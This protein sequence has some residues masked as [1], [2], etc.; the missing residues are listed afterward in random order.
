MKPM[1]LKK[2]RTLFQVTLH[3]M[4][5][6][7]MLL[8]NIAAASGFITSDL[9][10]IRLQEKRMLLRQADFSEAPVLSQE[11]LVQAP[12]S[13][14]MIG[15]DAPGFLRFAAEIDL[16]GDPAT[17][18]VQSSPAPV[19]NLAGKTYATAAFAVTVFS[20]SD[21][22]LSESIPVTFKVWHNDSLYTQEVVTADAWGAAALE[23]PFTN[24]SGTYTYQ[25]SSPGFGET[26]IRTFIFNP[27]DAAYTLSA[28][29]ARLSAEKLADG[30]MR[31]TLFSP[32]VLDP[33]DLVELQ[34]Y[35]SPETVP[36]VPEQLQAVAEQIVA[37]HTLLPLPY[38]A[39]QIVDEHTAVL[40]LT[41]PRGSYR[42]LGS[43]NYDGP[44]E[45]S[46]T[47]MMDYVTDEDPAPPPDARVQWVSP[48]EHETGQ[49][50]V[51]YEMPAGEAAL[52]LIDSV[53]GDELR[54]ALNQPV[55]THTALPGTITARVRTSPYTW[56]QESFLVEEYLAPGV[57]NDP[58]LVLNGIVYDP[59]TRKFTLN[60]QAGSEAAEIEEAWAV[61][62][63][64]GVVLDSRTWVENTHPGESRTEQIIA[65]ARLGKPQGLLLTLTNPGTREVLYRLRLSATPDDVV[66]LISEAYIQYAPTRA[67]DFLPPPPD[68]KP[69]WGGPDRAD[70]T[71]RDV[72]EIGRR[73]IQKVK[74]FELSIK[75]EVLALALEFEF[76][77]SVMILTVEMVNKNYIYPPGKTGEWTFKPMGA[78]VTEIAEAIFYNTWTQK[79]IA[80]ATGSGS[81]KIGAKGTVKFETCNSEEANNIVNTRLISLADKMNT[82]IANSEFM[83]ETEFGD[84]G[85]KTVG[86]YFNILFF[87]LDWGVTGKNFEAD[88]GDLSFVLNAGFK[89]EISINVGIALPEFISLESVKA[90]YVIIG[91]VALAGDLL[92]LFAGLQN[93]AKSGGCKLPPWPDDQPADDRQDAYQQASGAALGRTTQDSI[94]NLHMLVGLA[95]DLALERAERVLTLQLR[96]YELIQF[97]NNQSIY[98]EY[99]ALHAQVYDHAYAQYQA[100]LSGTVTLSPTQTITEAVTEIYA[101]ANELVNAHPYNI[102]SNQV[103]WKLRVA[104][105][106]YDAL[107]GQ[108][109]QTQE[110]MD[111]LLNTASIGVLASGIPWGIEKA[112]NNI[113]IPYQFVSLWGAEMYRSKPVYTGSP[114]EAPRTLVVPTAGLD[115]VS[116]SI[117]A[118]QW[119]DAYVAGGGTMLVFTQPSGAEWEAL[120]GGE[121]RGIGY[122]EDQ[123]CEQES[124]RAGAP[125]KWLVWMGEPTPDIQV[126]GVFTTWPPEAIPLLLRRS[127]FFEGFP[128]MLEYPYGEGTVLATTAYGDWAVESGIAWGDDWQMTRGLL[129]R[130]FLLNSGRDVEDLATYSPDTQIFPSLSF[131]N[132]ASFTATQVQTSLPIIPA[133]DPRI[134]RSGK[135]IISAPIVLDL[136][137][138]GFQEFA[139]GITTPKTLRGVHNWTQS[140]IFR[141]VNL[142]TTEGGWYKAWGP[143][144]HIPG[145]DPVPDFVL[146]LQTPFATVRPFTTIPV[147]A[148]VQNFTSLS[149][150]VVVNGLA[151][152]P[153]E[154][155]TLTVP[156]NGSASTTYHVLVET[157]LRMQA[158]AYAPN[159]TLLAEAFLSVQLSV[160]N[161]RVSVPL[162]SDL[163]LAHDPL[164]IKITN[165]PFYQF[166]SRAMLTSTL[167]LTLT[168]PTGEDVWS[169]SMGLPMIQ[170]ALS[171][172]VSATIQ[173]SQPWLP[174]TYL[175][176]YSI[177]EEGVT[178]SDGRVG[179]PSRIGIG[180]TFDAQSYDVSQLPGLTVN[181]EN[182]GFFHLSSVLQ[183]AV[184]SLNYV[185]TIA[186]DVPGQQL[187]SIPFAFTLPLSL[188]HG[189]Y[190]VM[191]T[192]V[193]E[194]ITQTQ[195][196]AFTVLPPWLVWQQPEENANPG[197]NER[198][199]AYWSAA[200]Q[201]QGGSRGEVDV[202]F[203]LIDW[204]GQVLGITEGTF[205]IGFREEITIP[206]NAPDVLIT[207]RYRLEARAKETST[208][209]TFSRD[210]TLDITGASPSMVIGPDKPRYTSGDIVSITGAVQPNQDVFT[211]TLDIEIVRAKAA[212][213]EIG[214][215][216]LL[217]SNE[218]T[219][220]MEYENV[221]VKMGPDG[222]AHAVWDT[223]ISWGENQVFYAFLSPDASTWS[224]SENFSIGDGTDWAENPAV[225]VD[226]QGGVHTIWYRFDDDWNYPWLYYA[227]RDPVTL[228]W[229]YE[230]LVSLPYYNPEPDIAVTSDGAVHVVFQEYSPSVDILYA[231]RAPGGGWSTPIRVNS[232]S[233]SAA[234]Y[235]PA[236]AV[237]DSDN[238]YV[239]WQDGRNTATSWDLYMD[240]LP[241]NGAWGT[242]ILVN[243]AIDN[244]QQ[245]RPDIDVSPD[246][247]VY[248]VWAD[249]RNADVYF[250]YRAAD[251]TW[252][253]E[254]KIINRSQG[255]YD[256]KVSVDGSGVAHVVFYEKRASN[257]A[258]DV[259]YMNRA[260]NGTWSALQV[261]NDDYATVFNVAQ[262]HPDAAARA[263]GEVI[264]LWRDTRLGS[265]EI[266]FGRRPAG[267]WSA[268]ARVATTTGGAG[269]DLPDSAGDG[270]GGLYATWQTHDKW[271]DFSERPAGGAW[272]HDVRL[273]NGKMPDVGASS[274][275]SVGVIYFNNYDIWARIRPAGGAW[276]AEEKV[277]TSSAYYGQYPLIDF[278]DAGNAYALWRLEGWQSNPDE[279]KFSYRP[280]GGVWQAEERVDENVN[281]FVGIPQLVVDASGAAHA[282]WADNRNGSWQMFYAYR[283]NGGS[284][285]P[286]E[287]VS[288]VGIPGGD[289]GLAV[290]GSGNVYA[291]WSG[292]S[293]IYLGY[294]PAGGAWAESEL[295]TS[296]TLAL[297]EY[298]PGIGLDDQ[299][300]IYISYHACGAGGG[301]PQCG[302]YSSMRLAGA[303][304]LAVGWTEPALVSNP[305][306]VGDNNTIVVTGVGELHV[307][308]K[309]ASQ[310][311]AASAVL[312]G[313]ESVAYSTSIPVNAISRQLID[314]NV[315]SLGGEPGKYWQQAALWSSLDQLAAR[316]R[317]PFYIQPEGVALTL[318]VG[319]PYAYPGQSLSA[320]GVLTNTG[321]GF[322][323]G[324]LSGMLNGV[325]VYTQPYN[326]A[327]GASISY[328]FTQPVAQD[329]LVEVEAGLAQASEFVIVAEPHVAAEILVPEFVGYSPFSATLVMTNT[330]TVPFETQAVL[331]QEQRLL[332]LLPGESVS[333]EADFTVAPGDMVAASLRGDVILDLETVPTWGEAGSIGLAPAGDL[334]AGTV[335][336]HYVVTGTGSLS[337][338][339]VA[340]F[341]LDTVFTREA[342]AD[343]AAFTLLPGQG[344]SGSVQLDAPAGVHTLHAI[345]LDEAGLT[346]AEDAITLN[347][348]PSGEDL[349]PALQILDV[350]ITQPGGRSGAARAG[351]GFEVAILV[352]NQGP[353]MPVIAGVQVFDLPYQWVFTP[354]AFTTSLITTT[355]DV[356]GDM[357]SGSYVGS[358]WVFDQ[359]A[360][361]EAPVVGVDV[362]M[363]LALGSPAYQPGEPVH[364]NVGLQENAGFSGAYHLS[365]RYLDVE[366]F[367]TVTLLAG[368]SIAHSFVFTA[369]MS[370]RASVS[371][372]M[373][374]Q[375]GDEGQRTIM[376]DSLPV[377]VVEPVNGVAVSFDKAVYQAGDTMQIS[378]TVSGTAESVLLWGLEEVLVETADFLLWAAPQDENLQVIQ[379]TYVV[380]LTLSPYLETGIYTL[381]LLSSG[382]EQDI[383]VDVQGV[384]VNFYDIQLDKPIYNPGDIVQA[385]VSFWNAGSTPVE[386]VQLRTEVFAPDESQLQG[387]QGRAMSMITLQPGLNIITTTALLETNQSGPHRLGASLYLPGELWAL[388]TAVAQ[389]DV[390]IGRILG[391]ST[392]QGIYQPGDAGF[393][394]VDLYGLGRLGL[395]ITDSLGTV[396][397]DAEVALGGFQT[398]TFALNTNTTGEVYL[399]A[400]SLDEVG[401]K[402][403]ASTYYAMPL[404][405]DVTGPEVRI[406]SPATHSVILTNVPTITLEIAGSATDER[407][408]TGVVVNGEPAILQPGGQFTASIV[409]RQ[410]M[411]LVYA[412]ARDAAGNYTYTPIMFVQLLPE[413]TIHV[414]TPAQVEVGQ[415][416]NVAVTLEAWGDVQGVSVWLKVDASLINGL[417]GTATSGNLEITGAEGATPTLNWV[418]NLEAGVPVV[419]T[420]QGQAQSAGVFE[421]GGLVSWSGGLVE[422]IP[423]RITITSAVE[424]FRIFLPLVFR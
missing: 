209:Q 317:V 270:L 163:N 136:P 309:S 125:S 90:M 258:E 201:N 295:F 327:P 379:G 156:A 18:P 420:F 215:S 227:Y 11:P 275:G 391:L 303:P 177:R 183:V 346:L 329:A 340:Q 409:L 308:W 299:G 368:Q 205:E 277:N 377:E 184:P 20:G 186:V 231:R 312:S 367:I 148:T 222:T 64:G 151:V 137:P 142:V 402:S 422:Q 93:Q 313:G 9:S 32:R 134:T 405:L 423:I 112:L 88:A 42:M 98:N 55:A 311:Y 292:S 306:L 321:Q 265:H 154:P 114:N 370:D 166:P 158:G 208:G 357:P 254:V 240:I 91:G 33:T 256:P 124:V 338:G 133:G 200:L 403:A 287:L 28:G 173:N 392:N 38:Q 276:L 51:V 57:E 386:D 155:V 339:A 374:P 169:H 45:I 105:G 19:I 171:E 219:G 141:L 252:Q 54:L 67:P 207:G 332:S 180:S 87:W 122:A 375:P 111:L 325:E 63:P 52:G 161:L 280:V 350:S 401:G 146:S 376:I 5:I 236:L 294:R 118:R 17:N 126:D 404:S 34:I 406:T 381:K 150:T 300:N 110:E 408:V 365:L 96:E 225:A 302:V 281:H 336:V 314:Q 214:P 382:L 363:T 267:T 164:F 76:K 364:L 99:R 159:R 31:V 185:E 178:M 190:P 10:P 46:L 179:I 100:I 278:D 221:Q 373:I 272:Q 107:Y 103:D 330:G 14:T 129:S 92:F 378:V 49:K 331:G 79:K 198:G 22:L 172:I 235:Y 84:A 353:A 417:A 165:E 181:L 253:N 269:H 362:D 15:S 147:T 102:L 410:G 384:M 355:L 86:P 233:G 216:I 210:F 369:T 245:T 424:G 345:L 58:P 383:P 108:E 62:G 194:G 85:K 170:P 230:W 398:I 80:L 187:L 123:R 335:T 356:P 274:S 266:F 72:S 144:V 284:W 53:T 349:V 193:T 7:G 139:P 56:V 290:D 196:N 211:G 145:T 343:S 348:L 293:N 366:E 182:T 283:P 60:W 82:I 43:I 212:S 27:F 132:M 347:L 288:S 6:C 360:R 387:V 385:V 234:Q 70:D 104:Q 239:I 285:Q 371:L 61:T 83:K 128:A 191:I 361:F 229:S 305:D 344:I 37:G 328:D 354:T 106:A 168:S 117:Y 94:N 75:N 21:R 400:R 413:H 213:A 59:V 273:A 206:V 2:I 41:L 47:D 36:V 397:L 50:I 25:A 197:G 237:D 95:Q 24:T 351:S 411:N 175:L 264:A 152:L 268:S 282:I 223:Q 247:Q 224:P 323:T 121:V 12:E 396:L 318:E 220:I 78:V 286:N 310:I 298:D 261:V 71:N 324:T 389:F 202:R 204:T 289:T 255:Q 416:I 304:P 238:V 319:A 162:G 291:I 109:A 23:L 89:G 40:E 130:L 232:D 157:S 8:P 188:T 176:T 380:T 13:L 192:L 131:T 320:A 296:S 393:G 421:P 262:R 81:V 395:V 3:I 412:A 337:T 226:A 113:G 167:A 415:E 116:Q 217:P 301:L 315:G 244:S 140:G 297:N 138:D 30:R 65:P 414:S 4:V 250:R 326:L 342:G 26:E 251:G 407:G 74:P 279:L 189:S 1:K 97:G 153:G 68:Y 316:S 333:I 39:F 394:Q 174:G 199:V 160:P 322:I 242:D 257:W 195:A 249:N 307:V 388:S 334:M 399:S 73:S 66:T 419:L 418:G 35:R 69:P 29:A 127:G 263:N 16:D 218:E 48:L 390:G 341:W 115:L 271:V 372:S 77:F 248:T 120:P 143:F 44:G 203:R 241:L 359:Y 101:E 149:Q 358:V 259:S 135:T 352:E 260:V 243:Q 119:L 246:G 228:V